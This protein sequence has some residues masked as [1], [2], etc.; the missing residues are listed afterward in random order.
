MPCHDCLSR[1]DFLARTAGAAAAAA[2]TSACGDGT[3]GGPRTSDLPPGGP[4]VITVGDFP[5]LATVGVPVAVGQLR[6]VMR[7]GSASFRALS[8][9]C[10]HEQCHTS[11]SSGKFTCPCHGSRFAADGRVE[12]GPAQRA[13]AVLATTYDSATDRLTIA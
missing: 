1:R 6:A 9:V 5:G 8:M 2:L 3:I 12:V 7:T 10:T 4:I 13:L 11:L